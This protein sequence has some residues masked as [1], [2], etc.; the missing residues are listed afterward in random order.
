[1]QGREN[2]KDNDLFYICSLIEYIAR[3]T[4]N[5]P[6]A[7]VEKL[8]KGRLQKI[9]ELADIYHCENIDS[10]SQE[11]IEK[12]D[13]QQGNFDNI[14]E[15]EYAVPTHWE[16]GKVYKRLIKSAAEDSGNDIVDTLTEVF[17]SRIVDLIENYNSS[18]Y[19]DNPG[20]ILAAYNNNC[21]PE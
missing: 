15:C 12:C 1:M 5:K 18:F 21:I 19:Y 2:K 11:L 7:V 13:I 10:V 4:K 16:I 14:S 6:S 20:A 3:S 9:Y 8:G 17:S